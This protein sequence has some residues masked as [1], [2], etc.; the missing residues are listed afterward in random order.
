M[1]WT[2]KMSPV[3][4]KARHFI[5]KNKIMIS[6]FWDQDGLIFMDILEKNTS[7]NKAISTKWPGLKDCQIK[8][9]QDNSRP[10]TAQQTLTQ[11]SRYGW[12]L[13]PHPAYSPDLSPSDFYLF[14]NLKNYLRGRTFENDEMLLY[15]FRKQKVAFYQSDFVSWKERW[16]NLYRKKLMEIEAGLSMEVPVL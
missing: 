15:E 4:K 11:T 9:H 5:S 8:F 3:K 10:H 2:H 14:G 13:M 12:T 7:I 16:T 6:V 1:Q